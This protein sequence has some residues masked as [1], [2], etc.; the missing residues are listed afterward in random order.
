M[1]Y[2]SYTCNNMDES[3]KHCAMYKKHHKSSTYCLPSMENAIKSKLTHGDI[4]QITG[5]LGMGTNRGNWLQMSI[6]NL[7]SNIL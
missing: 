7:E 3:Q 2:H 6:K 4:K 1:N 5:C